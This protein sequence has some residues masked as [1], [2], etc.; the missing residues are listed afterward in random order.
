M[1]RHEDEIQYFLGLN[2]FCRVANFFR[3][4]DDGP[5]TRS[6]SARCGRL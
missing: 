5:I 4:A 1:K 3:V 2:C 6:G